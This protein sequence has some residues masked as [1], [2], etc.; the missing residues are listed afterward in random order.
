MAGR[1]VERQRFVSEVWRG[2]EAEL[3]ST[4]ESIS[5]FDSDQEEAFIVESQKERESDDYY[6]EPDSSRDMPELTPATVLKDVTNEKRREYVP[7]R[8][9]KS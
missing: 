3:E 4:Q 2:S 1:E 9:W 8:Q 7:P 6:K 5:T